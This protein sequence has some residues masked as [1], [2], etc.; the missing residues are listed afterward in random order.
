MNIYE[1]ETL[2]QKPEELSDQ[3]AWK[4]PPNLVR[5]AGASRRLGDPD[6]LPL[7]HGRDR[8]GTFTSPARR[9]R[10]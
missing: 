2:E 4:G 10:R 3:A 7:G 9:L 5:K 1:D 6:P 8:C